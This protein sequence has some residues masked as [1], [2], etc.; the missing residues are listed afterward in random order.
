MRKHMNIDFVRHSWFTWWSVTGPKNWGSHK[1]EQKKKKKDGTVLEEHHQSNCWSWGERNKSSV[2]LIRSVSPGKIGRTRDTIAKSNTRFGNM[3]VL[4]TNRSF[5]FEL[6]HMNYFACCTLAVKERYWNWFSINH[7]EPF[8]R[9]HLICIP[10]VGYC[11]L[12][13]D[14]VQCK[15]LQFITFIKLKTP[16]I[17]KTHQTSFIFSITLQNVAML[18]Y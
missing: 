17:K 15:F 14:N 7:D 13:E 8:R 10:T 12:N 4:N 11:K 16:S 1:K 3:D 5:S 18:H 9:G 6:P 2:K